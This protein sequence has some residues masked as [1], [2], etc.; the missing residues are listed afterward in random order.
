MGKTKKDKNA[1]VAG[2]RKQTKESTVEQL[3]VLNCAWIIFQMVL[4]NL[5]IRGYQTHQKSLRQHPCYCCQVPK[6]LQNLSFLLPRFFFTSYMI[7]I[8]SSMLRTFASSFI[9]LFSFVLPCLL[10]F[11]G[12]LCF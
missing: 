7:A 11:Q 8:V 5:T 1:R 2:R 3:C 12:G 4:L 10:L 6:F 9:A